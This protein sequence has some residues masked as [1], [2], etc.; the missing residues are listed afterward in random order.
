MR[1]AFVL[2][3]LAPVVV[4]AAA[5]GLNQIPTTDLVPEGQVLLQLQNGNTDVRGHASMFHQPQ[6]TPQSQV[7]M[8]WNLEA[9]IDVAPSNPPHDYRPATNLKW[10]PLDEDYRVPA[11]ALGVQ[12]LGPGFTPSYYVTLSKTLN[13]DAIQYQKFRAHHRNIKLRGIRIHAGVLGSDNVWHALVGT[14]VEVNDHLV[15]YADWISGAASSVSLGGV[16]VFG[17][18]D[19]VQ[20][21]LLRENDRDRLTGLIIAV[22]HTFDLDHPLEW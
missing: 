19:S 21:A 14:D 15:L 4:W 18:H 6:L 12:Q 1:G 20:A 7:G 22:T 5:T 16:L 3:A 10:R 13:Y 17:P 11:L 8:P 2:V 9:G